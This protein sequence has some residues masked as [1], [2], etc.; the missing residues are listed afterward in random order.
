M[1]EALRASESRYREL[2]EMTSDFVYEAETS[3]DG[4][5]RVR[6]VSA[7]VTDLTGYSLT[8]LEAM[9]GSFAPLVI[10]QD[11]AAYRRHHGRM[12]RGES[13]H[14]EVR[15]RRKDGATR[16]LRLQSR[17]ESDLARR[18]GWRRWIGA[19]HDITEQKRAEEAGSRLTTRLDRERARMNA[20]L[21][22]T[23]A[24]VWEGRSD[25]DGANLHLDFVSEYAE[26]LTGYSVADWLFTPDFWRSIVHPDDRETAVLSADSR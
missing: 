12:Q 1:E 13:S 8:E 10:E 3:P 14:C 4:R 18:P 24:L 16:W 5:R 6:W 26:R 2:A 21:D 22:S 17:P 9:G 25:A 7:A 23:P 15:I 11:H 20:I 19:V